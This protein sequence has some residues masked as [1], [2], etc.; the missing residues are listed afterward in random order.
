[1]EKA[2]YWALVWGTVVMTLT[3]LVL[4]FVNTAIANLPLWTIDLAM[5]IHYWE[6]LLAC[7]AI[8]VW[9]GYW[10]VL[11]PEYYPL[12]LTW[13]LGDPRPRKDGVE[14]EEHK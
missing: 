5:T 4:Y 10:V 13:L 9:H 1:M 12:N 14:K 7:L 11:D 2:E 8:I 6:A 3:G